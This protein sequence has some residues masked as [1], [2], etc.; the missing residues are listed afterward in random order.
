[1]DR[2]PGRNGVRKHKQ[3]PS[4]V[5]GGET[6][7]LPLQEA[8]RQKPPHGQD[9]TSLTEINQ[10]LAS[11]SESLIDPNHVQT[12]PINQGAVLTQD[13]P[14]NMDRF[15]RFPINRSIEQSAK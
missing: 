4:N 5:K 3:S 9:F 10:L 6:D 8:S 12:I 11:S 2:T 13:I 14:I 7:Q 15:K 1:M